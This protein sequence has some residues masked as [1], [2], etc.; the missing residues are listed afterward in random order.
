MGNLILETLREENYF[1]KRAAIV[2]PPESSYSRLI[3]LPRSIKKKSVHKHVKSPE[4]QVQIPISINQTDFAIYETDFQLNIQPNSK[5]YQIVATPKASID[6]LIKTCE[7][8]N[9]ELNYV[10]V[11]FNSISRL[12]N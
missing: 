4:S 6:N 8:A 12:I 10:E 2:L 3:E 5:T 9:L 1:L 11:G 7:V